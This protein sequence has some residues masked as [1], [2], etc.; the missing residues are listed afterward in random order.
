M[1]VEAETKPLNEEV[2]RAWVAKG[3]VADEGGR[4]RR[5]QAL[6]IAPIAGLMFAAFLWSRSIPFEIAIRFLVSAGGIAVMVQCLRTHRY[7]FAPVFAGLAILFNPIWPVFGF[8]GDWPR[9]LLM[10][11]TVP[12][13]AS[14]AWRIPKAA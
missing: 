8:S 1:W 6:K 13:V 11:C 5:L 7:A 2:W 12:F 4:E 10:A 9:A 3:R 14:L